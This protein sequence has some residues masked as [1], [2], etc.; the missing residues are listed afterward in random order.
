MQRLLIVACKRECVRERE[1]ERERESTKRGEGNLM[2][3]IVMKKVGTKLASEK[4]SPSERG[5]GGRKDGGKKGWKSGWSLQPN[6]KTLNFFSA[7]V[8]VFFFV[9]R[10]CEIHSGSKEHM[11]CRRKKQSKEVYKLRYNKNSL[12]LSLFFS[13]S[14]F[15]KIGD[16]IFVVGCQ[17]FN[18][19][20]FFWVG[21]FFWQLVFS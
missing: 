13:L 4:L 6:K 17:F 19:R 21:S 7:R 10:D 3:W 2:G 14:Q 9:E 11:H 1:L 5:R 16:V 8:C 20:F 18:F 12:S 15:G